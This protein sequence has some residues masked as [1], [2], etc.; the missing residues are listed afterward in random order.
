VFL[1]RGLLS[2]PW[3]RELAA[4]PGVH[5]VDAPGEIT[6]T[7]ERLNATDALVE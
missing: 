4:R 5:V 2:Q 7:I 3:A 6:M 1:L